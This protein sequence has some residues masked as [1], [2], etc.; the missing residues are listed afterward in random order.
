MEER[1]RCYSF[2]LSQIPHDTEIN[3]KIINTKDKHDKRWTN[4]FTGMTTMTLRY[5][6]RYLKLNYVNNQVK[7]QWSRRLRKINCYSLQWLLIS[8]LPAT[9]EVG[10]ASQGHFEPE[11]GLGNILPH[12]KQYFR[13]NDI[14]IIISLSQSTAGHRPLQ[15][16]D[17][18]LDLRLLARY[19]DNI[20]LFNRMASLNNAI[21]QICYYIVDDTRI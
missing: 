18:S 1:E 4:S 19:F 9:T 20:V 15:F 8:L 6:Y 11:N 3:D 16:L 17:I 12:L 5:S 2:I 13:E 21:F 10:R 14:F 7:L